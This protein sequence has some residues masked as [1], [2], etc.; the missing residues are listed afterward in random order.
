[1]NGFQKPTTLA[2]EIARNL[3]ANEIR[4]IR[5]AKRDGIAV[6]LLEESDPETEDPGRKA[7]PL[8]AAGPSPEEETL[9]KEQVAAL[10]A[11]VA[12]L[13]PQMRRCVQLRIGQERKYREIA[14]I[15]GT[16]L[17]V[18]KAQIGQAKLRL[19]DLLREGAGL[20]AL[21]REDDT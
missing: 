21:D 7:P 8:A 4:G 9:R 17:D 19:R 12:T 3:R 13:P 18:V 14:E 1:M 16:S 10:R 15:L 11:A 2:V 6:P 5:A 20:G